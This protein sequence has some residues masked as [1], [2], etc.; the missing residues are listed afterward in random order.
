MSNSFSDIGADTARRRIALA[1]S[2]EPLPDNSTIKPFTTKVPS[3]VIESLDLIATEMDIPRNTLVSKLI[4]SYLGCALKEYL[5]G[6]WV[7]FGMTGD[8]DKFALESLE[9]LFKSNE[10]TAEAR[11]F[12]SRTLVDALGYGD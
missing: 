3:Y 8:P 1:E 7:E 2:G 12:L 9:R 6:S 10:I 11:S 5:H 4:H